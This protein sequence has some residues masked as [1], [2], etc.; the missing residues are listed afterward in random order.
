MHRNLRHLNCLVLPLCLALGGCGGLQLAA[1]D[2]VRIIPPGDGF[3][4]VRVTSNARQLA[5]YISDWK[6]LHIYA[7]KDPTRIGSR[8]NT[9]FYE[10]PAY[11][12]PFAKSPLFIGF[13][14]PGTYRVANLYGWSGGTITRTLVAPADATLGA[15]QVQAD[16]IA[17]LGTLIYQPNLQGVAEQYFVARVEN[18]ESLVPF[19]QNYFYMK[20][21]RFT[22]NTGG[23][24][25]ANTVQSANDAL[26]KSAGDAVLPTGN[27][28]FSSNGSAVVPAALGRLLVRSADGDWSVHDTGH[29]GAVLAATTL[30]DGRYMAGGEGGFLV[31]GDPSGNSWKNIK[32]FG[33]NKNIDA[34]GVAADGTL[35]AAT[36]EP[37]PSS[38]GGPGSAGAAFVLSILAR[39]PA[40]EK[41]QE[42]KRFKFIHV[43]RDDYK[44][45]AI[46]DGHVYVLNPDD[47]L[48][49]YSTADH[50]WHAYSTDAIKLYPTV[51]GALFASYSGLVDLAVSHDSGATWQQIKNSDNVQFLASDGKALLFMGRHYDRDSN[52]KVS[53]LST[54]IFRTLDGTKWTKL[55][56]IPDDCRYWAGI[57]GHGD[58]MWLVCNNG[59]IGRIHVGDNKFIVERKVKL[60]TGAEAAANTVQVTTAN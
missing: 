53:N 37:V 6:F 28:C 20:A 33:S 13:L 45:V 1:P 54:A 58:D 38:P 60:T 50:V 44:Q 55:A 15:F 41:W 39:A 19:V 49:V 14:P 9:Q 8:N 27:F 52:K 30:P 42:I 21:G 36:S 23:P 18:S 43:G 26:A 2:S 3:V 51:G 35:Y 17:D 59:T 25:L 11:H 40:S 7:Y 10:L 48:W 57:A 34:L 4:V 47:K 29:T 46:D 31:V 56:E 22:A 32:G 16:K 24:W 12:D 5:K